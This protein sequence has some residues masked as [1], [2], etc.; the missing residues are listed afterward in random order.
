MNT[1][2]WSDELISITGIDG[3]KLP[4]LR[5]STDV[6]GGVTKEAAE[7]TGLV[8]GTPVVCG[9]GAKGKVWRQI[10]ADMFNVK[11]LKPNYLE[12]ATSMGAAVTGGV[13]S[14][15][16]RDFDVI[17]KFINIEEIEEPIEKNSRKYRESCES[18]CE[19]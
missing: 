18:G 19:L 12:E 13:G 2:K 1:Y 3:D 11:I 16:F 17:D 6:I 15:V 10:M 5:K 4:E 14:G 9:G 8:E 7:L